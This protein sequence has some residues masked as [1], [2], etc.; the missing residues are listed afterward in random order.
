MTLLPWEQLPPFIRQ[1]QVAPYYQ[2]L[3]EK[4]GQLLAKRVLDLTLAMAGVVLLWP[5]GLAV[6]AAVYLQDRGPVFFFQQRITQYGRPFWMV[7]FRTMAP[8]AGGAPLTAAGDSRVTPVGRLLRRSH[9]DELPQLLHVI[10]GEMSLVGPRPEV[11]Q[12]VRRYP[13]ELRA[14]LLVPAGITSRG[15][16]WAAGCEARILAASPQPEQLYLQWVMPR[17]LSLELEALRHYS[18]GGQARVLLRTACPGAWLRPALR[19][20]PLRKR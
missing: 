5:V 2:A 17:K 10:R 9:L 14:T 6:A 15:A 7:K 11:P 20:S 16:L 1:P 4:K 19:T 13:P 8:Q 12:Y 3:Q 18:L